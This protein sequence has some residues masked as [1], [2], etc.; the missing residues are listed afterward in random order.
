MFESYFA[1]LYASDKPL[2]TNMKE[3]F[4]HLKL[5]VTSPEQLTILNV[6]ISLNKIMIVIDTLIKFL[7]QMV[8]L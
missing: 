3:F 7:A 4:S 6:P 8:L 2:V 1:Q 5:S